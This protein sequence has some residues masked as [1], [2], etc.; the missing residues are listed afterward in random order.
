MKD[1]KI[2]TEFGVIGL[3]RFGLALA[4]T[5]AAAEKEV[6]VID[7]DE[8]KVREIRNLIPDSFVL[9]KLT[10]E[11]LE[12]TGIQNCGTVIMCIAEK[13][14]VSILT[15]MT[16]I[17]MG[18]PRVISKATSREHGAILE[19]IGADVVYPERDTAIRLAGVLLESDALD[20]MELND[21]YVVS[22][23][24]IPHNLE[25]HTLKSLNLAKYNL[26]IAALEKD[27]YTYLDF[28]ED[29]ILHYNDAIL[30]LGK[31]S[32]VEYFEEKVRLKQA[33][34]SDLHI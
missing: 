27:P 16:L 18:I 19:K 17:N 2:K 4:K 29:E 23:I 24:K 14:D 8:D 25:G 9:E 6:L 34:S 28:R 1:N 22:E 3:G 33:K 21:D 26:R 5:L 13:I 20:L 30:V 10:K 11:S 31:F 32:D 7:G 15:T 12:E